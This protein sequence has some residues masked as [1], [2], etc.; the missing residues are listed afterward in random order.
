MKALILAGGRG[1]RLDSLTDA[2]NKC[3]LPL[4][5]CPLVEYSLKNAIAAGVSEVV[6]VV[7]HLAEQIINAYG[8][9]FQGTPIRYVIQW[10]QRGLV[11]AV[12]CARGAIGDSDFMLFLADEVL[13][14][15]R[16]SEMMETFTS[17]DLC[18][19]CGVIEVEDRSQ[20]SKTYAIIRGEDDT[21]HRLIEKPEHPMNDVMGTGNVV[22]D[23]RIFDYIECTPINQQRGEKELPDLIQCAIDDGQ[24]VKAFFIG[25]RYVNVNTPDEI[26]RA[27]EALGRDA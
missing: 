24:A 14:E 13:I 6:L 20:I 19:L 3:M 7:G 10:E 17:E 15:P 2:T 21:I 26:G 25:S 12:E 11:H 22:F 4:A 23:N 18:V 27:E 8:N 16:H 9:V 5:G 1:S